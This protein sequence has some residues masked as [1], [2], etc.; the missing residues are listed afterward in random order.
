MHKFDLPGRIMRQW[1]GA[2][3]NAVNLIYKSCKLQNN[4]FKCVTK[5]PTP[6]SAK[7]Y[8]PPPHPHPPPPPFLPTSLC[9]RTGMASDRKSLLTSHSVMEICF[10]CFTNTKCKC[11]RCELPICNKCSVL[12][13]LFLFFVINC[14]K[15]ARRTLYFGISLASPSSNLLR[16][17]WIARGHVQCFNEVQFVSEDRCRFTVCWTYVFI[18]STRL[19]LCSPGSGPKR[20]RPYPGMDHFCSHGTVSL[21]NVSSHGTGLLRFDTELK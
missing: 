16:V 7:S 18:N 8:C 6:P 14:Q 4:C 2:S 1:F 15:K 17:Q 3:A 10:P 5:I 20:I 13:L 19:R 11:L 9:F 12:S 21:S